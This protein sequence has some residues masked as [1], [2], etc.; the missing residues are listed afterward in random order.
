MSE[1]LKEKIMEAMKQSSAKNKKK[2]YI[3]DLAKKIEGA[4]KREVQNVVKDLI[5]EDKLAYWSSGSTTY[6]MLKEDY[7]AYRHQAED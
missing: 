5:A 3:K 1:D 6:I 7:D 2:L 4:S